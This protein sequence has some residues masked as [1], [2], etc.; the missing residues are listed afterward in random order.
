V[1]RCPVC[2]ARN[3][4]QRICYRCKT[5]VGHLMD[6]EE[7]ARKHLEAAGAAFEIE[8][9]EQMFF[10]AKRSHSLRHTPESIR[11]LACAALLTGKFDPAFSL[12][13]SMSV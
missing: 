3:N 7:E 13:N 4:G 2:N 10:H 12:W 6:I 8:D 5:D 9:Y 11:I 1:E